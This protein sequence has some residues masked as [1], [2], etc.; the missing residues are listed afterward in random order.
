[1]KKKRVAIINYGMGNLR[2]VEVSL[3]HLGIQ[4]KVISNPTK[5]IGFSHMILPGVG[6]FKKA[7]YNLKK[8]GF[9]EKLPEILKNQNIKILGICLGMQLL[10]SSS[11][12]D[13]LTKGLN[14]LKGKV[15]KFKKNETKNLKVPHVGFNQIKF[16]KEI[17]LL[18]DIQNNSDFY[19]DHS[20]RITKIMNNLEIF[21][22]NYGINFLAGF[23]YK[24]I[25]AT[26]FHPEKSQSN[27]LILL[28]NF[29]D[30]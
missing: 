1:M 10:F 29:M 3:S 23:S 20:Y 8:L 22:C 4:S 24:N 21:E 11:N 17:P 30:Q 19:F 14:L 16:K 26:Q 18:K 7:V 5:L 25:F 15:L 27:G 13:G 28:K 6:S 12:E 9:F 2:S